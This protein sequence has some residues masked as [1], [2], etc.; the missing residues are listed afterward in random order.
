[1]LVSALSGTPVRRDVAMTGE[2]TLLGKVLPIG[3]LKEKTMAAYRAGIK[4]V[5]IPKDNEPDL[6]EI[7][8]KVK[9]NLHFVPA[10]DISTV[11][12][13]ALIMPNC[14]TEGE[15]NA[16]LDDKTVARNVQRKKPVL[17]A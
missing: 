7:D 15:T 10:E 17:N 6:E 1:A 4:T 5:C 11:L 2:I 16:A 9:A 13:T 14:K 12:E 3:G 8:D